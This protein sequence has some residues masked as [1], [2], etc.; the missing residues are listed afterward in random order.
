[1]ERWTAS[2]AKIAD[3]KYGS[4][5]NASSQFPLKRHC[6]R[7]VMRWARSLRRMNCPC[8]FWQRWLSMVRSLTRCS[9][10]SKGTIRSI[11]WPA[12]FVGR[13]CRF[14]S[15]GSF[16]RAWALRCLCTR[17][18]HSLSA[19]CCI[20]RAR[21][22]LPSKPRPATRLCDESSASAHRHSSRLLYT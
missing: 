18:A 2:A 7:L 9:G 17:Q 4:S 22:C 12:R 19:K 10:I 3:S 14:W 5:I 1:M 8:H 11:G 21:C 13:S 20:T 6:S 15:P 16:W